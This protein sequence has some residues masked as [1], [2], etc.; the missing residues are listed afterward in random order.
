MNQD[1]H[2]VSEELRSSARQARK[3]LKWVL[4]A[5]AV[6]YLGSGFFT[7]KSNELGVLEIMGKVVDRQVMPGLHYSYPRPFSRVYKVPVS[8]SDSLVVDDFFQDPSPESRASL[9]YGLTGLES[10]ALSGD[11][12]TV[13]IKVIL[14]YRSTDPFQSLFGVA[15]KKILLRDIVCRE[16]IHLLAVRP[17]DLVLTRGREVIGQALHAGI[18]KRCDLNRTGI[19][20]D[21][22]DIQE[23]RP[24][25]VVQSFF[26][27]VINAQIDK[28]QM[29]SRA[30][31]YATAEI[32]RARAEGDRLVREGRTYRNQVI[33]A[34]TGESERFLKLLGEYRKVPEITRKRLYLEFAR[35]CL[36]RLKNLYLV[37]RRESA[38]PV[39]LRVLP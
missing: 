9:F 18:Q 37:D 30:E 29:E 4:L 22:V 31:S 34:A 1:Q 3:F 13:E 7:I 12:N 38:E 23:I 8:K 6:F 2:S 14:H 15:Q 11:N 5:L 19:T 35:E 28:V 21:R 33:E 26:D 16:I 27:D 17:I 25:G 32:A 10:Y 20:V 24:P 36:N 39:R